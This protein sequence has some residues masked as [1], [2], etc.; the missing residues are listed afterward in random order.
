LYIKAKKQ[1]ELFN[2]TIVIYIDC[3]WHNFLV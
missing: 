3:G 2:P 1:T